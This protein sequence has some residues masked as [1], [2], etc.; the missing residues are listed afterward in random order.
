MLKKQNKDVPRISIVIPSLNKGKYIEKTL[1]SIFSQNYKNLEVF[2]QD[3]GSTDET[4]DIIRKYAEKYPDFLK[5]ESKKDNG[6]VF[7]IN[8]GLKKATGDILT[9]VNADDYYKN[10]AFERV[11]R[12]YSQRNEALWFVGFSDI[13]DGNGRNISGFVTLYK[14][15][16]TR[17]NSYIF[18]LIVNYMMQP[19]VFFTKEAFRKFG[20]LKGPRKF[21]LEY[22]FWLKLG[23][24]R[25]P[26]IIPLY[27]ASFRMSGTNL[28]SVLYRYLLRMDME[29]V[30]RYTK[31]PLVITLHKLHNLVR[32]AV[33]N[34][35]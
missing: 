13:V 33:V 34:S 5:W 1:Q 6:Q 18:L 10:G 16:L 26:V 25:M 32:I 28:S 29:T 31:S 3:G 14:N 9:Y 24:D 22:D 11:A 2:V 12:A 4:L 21:V 23:R 17:I 35:L 19:A 20:P 15:F 30:K 27:L 8:E 7:A